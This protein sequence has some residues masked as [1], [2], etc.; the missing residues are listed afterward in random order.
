MADKTGVYHGAMLAQ[1]NLPS[2]NMFVTEGEGLV[3][4]PPTSGQIVTA[5]SSITHHPVESDNVLWNRVEV[6]LSRQ[7]T[8]SDTGFYLLL[9]LY[10]ITYLGDIVLVGESP[11]I[12]S[13]PTTLTSETIVFDLLRSACE[14]A[15]NLNNTP[16]AAGKIGVNLP[17]RWANF[18]EA[19]LDPIWLSETSWQKRKTIPITGGN[20]TILNYP[21]KITLAYDS[22]MQTDFDD[23][24][25]TDA[26]AK[27]LLDY[28][29]YSKTD[30]STA[31][32]YVRIPS[33]PLYLSGV[34]VRAYYG[35]GAAGS[36]S[37][38]D[39][40][41]TFA[42][43]FN[44]N[45]IDANK[46]QTVSGG[47]GSI[48]ETN[49]EIRV[50][51]DGTN[52]I[53]LRSKPQFTAPYIFEFKGKIGQNIELAF[54]WDGIVS[55]AYDLPYNG[56]YLQYSGWT[57]PAKFTLYKMVNGS[58]I[59]L[60]DYNITLNSNYHDYKI[61]VT[62]SGN[63]NEIRVF[64]DGTEILYS[65]DAGPFNTGY[66]GFTAREAP[67]ALNAYYDFVRAYPSNSATPVIG[68]VG[69][70][71]AYAT[72]SPDTPDEDDIQILFTSPAGWTQPS[73]ARLHITRHMG[74]E[75]ITRP[76]MLKPTQTANMG[77]YGLDQ[78]NA[79]RLI[80]KIISDNN[81]MAKITEARFKYII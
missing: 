14:P 49:Q 29:L 8:G 58:Q 63:S 27:T 80:P 38:I 69:N 31:T 37:N 1:D 32:F 45:S 43:D 16:V 77:P 48:A 28:Y 24:R 65:I 42:D 19:H 55:G 67:A 36:L 21:A 73:P 51:S 78:F 22:D 47:G 54:N 13:V 61:Q 39:N 60:D 44:D 10:G 18:T 72:I 20:N 76:I 26:D 57:S 15:F 53:Y 40:V 7:R 4:S 3:F 17:Y 66:L 71:E 33:I 81:Y 70:E 52:R 25:F 2:P 6:D 5:E 41:F 12:T 23:I 56:Y 68:S 74:N 46:W 30:S 79:L 64:Y 50:T 11:P 34:P 35:D 75:F 62:K 9:S 59:W